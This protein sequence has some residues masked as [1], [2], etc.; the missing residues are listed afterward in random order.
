M[1]VSGWG[2]ART[3]FVLGVVW[4]VVFAVVGRATVT[5][6]QSELEAE[7]ADPIERTPIE[8]LPPVSEKTLGEADTTAAEKTID[9]L[10]TIVVTATRT[11]QTLIDVPASIAVQDVGE[12]RRNGFTFGTDEFRGVTGVFFRRGRE[13]RRRIPVGFFPRVD[14]N[15]R[16][17]QSY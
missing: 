6:A 1:I 13:W 5:W 2:E 11:E 4:C 16:R 17:H 14:R 12:L 7:T 3:L 9:E 10:N 8:T 15:R